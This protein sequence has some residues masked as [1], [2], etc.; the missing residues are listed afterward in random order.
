MRAIARSFE[1]FV[2]AMMGDLNATGR[3]WA[4]VGVVVLI[5][6]AAMSWGF[7]AD[8]SWKHGAF[9]ACLTFVAAFGPE[10]A[11]RAWT[12]GKPASAIAIAVLCAPLL[13]IEFY[14]HAGYTAGLRGHNIETTGVAN[15]RY[16][17]R[18][19]EVKEGKASLV[20]WEKRLAELEAANAWSAT[21]TAEALRAQLASATLAIEQEAARGGCKAKCLARTKERDDLASKIA[22]AEE[23]STLSKQIE[24]TKA[25]LAKAR[26]VAAVTEHK[27]SPVVH[28]NQFLA[29]AVTLVGFGSLEPTPHITA[30]AEQSANLA[31]AVAGTGLPAFCLFI[32]GLY[33][34]KED[35]QADI[36]PPV[37]VTPAPIVSHAMIQ[38]E[39]ARPT[40]IHTR[41]TIKD[42]TLRRW[43]VRDEVSRM[44]KVA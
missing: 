16:D 11:H 44:L 1:N 27:S 6:A 41:E 14:S 8:V 5:V 23:R 18:Q 17:Q 42:A 7:G 24:A 29:K 40:V 22:I 10:A 32:A 26:D 39:P 12:D 43:S 21:V 35:H 3:V 30:A 33:R 38:H 9:L 20:L 2:T 4:R 13:A 15:V 25:V 36:A 34:R 28:Q 19:D 31:M 37:T